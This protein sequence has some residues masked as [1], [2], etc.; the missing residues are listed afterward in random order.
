MPMKR[1]ELGGGTNTDGSK[2]I[3]YCSHCY[4]DGDFKQP[5]MTVHEMQALVK[6]KLRGIG[7]PGFVA[8]MFTRGIPKL[9]RWQ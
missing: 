7:F 1:D 5:E 4:A 9:A 3:M 6:D 2:S 8:G